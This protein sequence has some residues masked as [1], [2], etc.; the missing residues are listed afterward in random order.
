VSDDLELLPPSP[1]TGHDPLD[2]MPRA[3]AVAIFVDLRER[4][5]DLRKT[6]ESVHVTDE[7]QVAMMKIA[8]V[9]RLEFK[10]LR[11][12]ADDRHKELT[13][14]M[15]KRKRAIDADRREI[16][17]LC[18]DWETK[19]LDAE[20]FGDRMIEARQKELTQWRTEQVQPYVAPLGLT[21]DA[22][23]L[24]LISSEQFDALMAQLGG[25]LQHKR[26][27]EAAALRAA[28]EQEAARLAEVARLQA[29]N[30]KLEREAKAAEAER[31]RVA[32]ET[33]RREA[34]T[35]AEAEAE[36]RRIA[37]EARIREQALQAEADRKAAELQQQRDSEARQLAAERK[38]A[39]D[40][41]DAQREAA[42]AV[43][44]QERAKAKALQDQIDAETARRLQEAAAV[45]EAAR[46][47]AAAGDAE[48]IRTY[49]AQLAGVFCPIL[50]NQ[51]TGSLIAQQHAKFLEWLER[52]ASE[53]R[54]R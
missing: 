46:K 6:A 26:D 49:A 44:A 42:E 41:L 50:A 27:A 8:R 43:A 2:A 25:D 20:E 18:Q 47:L 53:M 34:D 15:T 33:A 5:S 4:L 7:S 31:Q 19:M 11:L 32:Q 21:V 1:S 36:Q 52:K 35:R 51:A 48:K 13:E 9:T 23:K 45:A 40:A 16:R 24:D 37:A 38:V 17:D 29:E 28:E 14:D 30:A 22:M 3:D 54:V 10:K 12:L 39:Q